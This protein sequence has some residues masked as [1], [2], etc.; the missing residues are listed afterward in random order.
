MI[1][2][3][4]KEKLNELGLSTEGKKR[5]LVSRLQETIT[6]PIQQHTEEETRET[7]DKSGDS[8]DEQ[9]GD[10]DDK[11]EEGKDDET[12]DESTE[13]EVTVPEEKEESKDDTPREETPEDLSHLRTRVDDKEK[14]EGGEQK[15]DSHE[16]Q[17]TQ[18]AG[19]IPS[20]KND[21]EHKV[22][23]EETPKRTTTE[24]VDV[25]SSRD[26]EI[27]AEEQVDDKKEDERAEPKD[28]SHDHETESKS[29]E[30]APKS[31]K[32]KDKK[33]KEK[34]HDKKKESE[35]SSISSM[36][37]RGGDDASY[38]PDEEKTIEQRKEGMDTDVPVSE[39][40]VSSSV[41]IYTPRKSRRR[42]NGT[43]ENPVVLDFGPEHPMIE[44]TLGELR[45]TY[46]IKC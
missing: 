11:E 30:Y 14:S 40:I 39:D 16:Q 31:R 19:S 5:D 25:Q 43:E 37:E 41:S 27:G 36:E 1:V 38:N 44:D 46:S 6:S 26:T 42:K 8:K 12:K 34:K 21:D 24:T 7:R 45:V 10:A 18:V 13:S 17:T 20:S 22:T 29:Q 32:A 33:R 35:N 4:L 15:D 2:A 23:S 9:T 3:E 28:D